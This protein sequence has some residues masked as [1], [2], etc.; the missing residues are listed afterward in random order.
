MKKITAYFLHLFAVNAVNRKKF[1]KKS[2]EMR[3]IFFHRLHCFHRIPYINLH[4]S[5][6]RWILVTKAAN[7]AVKFCKNWGEM[8]WNI[9]VH[10]IHRNHRISYKNSPHSPHFLQKVT[11]K[12]WPGSLNVL[13]LVIANSTILRLLPCIDIISMYCG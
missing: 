8:W 12:P 6:M 11:Q 1:C 2:C 5:S 9:L 3:W 10:R 13:W 7:I 4:Q